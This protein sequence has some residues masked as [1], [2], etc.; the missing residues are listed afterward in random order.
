MV[1]SSQMDHIIKTYATLAKV[2]SIYDAKLNKAN[3]KITSYYTVR[4]ID[5]GKSTKFS[6]D[7]YLN[8]QLGVAG[9]SEFGSDVSNESLIAISPSETYKAVLRETVVDKDAK[10]YFL[11]IWNSATLISSIDLSAFDHLHK[12]VYVDSEF[13]CLSWS[14]DEKQLLY[15]AEKKIKPQRGYIVRKPATESCDLGEEY[16]FKPDWGEQLVGKKMSVVVVYNIESE[17][18]KV[19][20]SVPEHLCPAHVIFSPDGKGVVG[21]AFETNPRRYGLIFCTNRPSHVFFMDFDGQYERLTSVKSACRS[22]RFNNAGDKLVWLQRW[23]DGPHHACHQ[24]LCVDWPL[25]DKPKILIDFVEKSMPVCNGEFT[26]LYCLSLP[27]RCFTS[28][29]KQIVFSTP[30]RTETRSFFYD[31]DTAKIT[32]MSNKEV[33]G[34]TTVLDVN[35]DLVVA[36]RTNLTTPTELIVTRLRDNGK[37]NWQ[38]LEHREEMKSYR[39]DYLEVNTELESLPSIPA[40]YMGPKEVRDDVK[41]P[42]IVWPHG[43]PHSCFTNSYSLEAALFAKLGFALLQ[44]N[45]RGST[46]QGQSCVDTL[47]GRA[48]LD[49]VTDCKNATD[50]AVKKF[51][52]DETKLLLYGGSHGGYLV[53]H[54]SGQ[55]PDRYAVVVTRNPVIDI[56]IMAGSTDIPDWCA[57]ES[58]FEYSEK[59][60]LSEL[61]LTAMRRCSPI[62]HVHRVKAPTAIMLGSNDK[63]VPCHQ[64]IEYYRRLRANGCETKLYLYED[65]H[66]LSTQSV[67]IDNLINGIVWFYRHMAKE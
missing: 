38:V 1:D 45:Y 27:K 53:T 22:P 3:N 39:V 21:V 49:D 41:L 66:S 11:E 47:P 32:D 10:K 12:D 31:F 19:L 16:T 17:T 36:M 18:F 25:K 50:E 55:Y 7:Y 6:I 9:K 14:P 60:P 59:G 51:P 63:R 8:E 15:V 28:E 2:P 61:E 48:G 33:A 20:D 57:V 58:G 54:L 29:D 13:G 26:G 52:I 65:N 35:K 4:N 62:A 5:K 43:G 67:E 23:A 34:S 56:A 37:V 30:Q 40:I 46:G 24:L 44:V 64:G 42:L